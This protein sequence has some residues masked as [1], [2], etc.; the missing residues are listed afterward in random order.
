MVTLCTAGRREQP[1]SP[2]KKPVTIVC[3]LDGAGPRGRASAVP[4][5][6]WKD[7]LVWVRDFAADAVLLARL[8]APDG[9]CHGSLRHDHLVDERAGVLHGERDLAGGDLGDVGADNIS[10]S[11]TATVPGGVTVGVAAAGAG[12]VAGTC[13]RTV[14]VF[15]LPVPTSETT[16]AAT[17]TA[18]AK[19][20]NS[21]TKPLRS[22]RLPVR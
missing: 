11:F 12:A 14:R 9:N 19:N 2:D 15:V 4:D 6:A 21:T 22:S 5:F 17:L 7:A 1:A 3:L 16:S 10:P 18:R 13:S 20:T 8:S